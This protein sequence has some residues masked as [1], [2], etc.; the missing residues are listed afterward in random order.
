MWTWL[1]L[2]T[3]AEFLGDIFV[4]LFGLNRSRYQDLYDM[5]VAEE[6]RAQASRLRELRQ[7]QALRAA[8]AAALAA[9]TAPVTGA[10]AGD[11]EEG[12][13]TEV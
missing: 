4:D 9:A 7:L 10:A 3:G 6:Q 13:K 12:E 11:V 8:E 1:A 5:H 2:I